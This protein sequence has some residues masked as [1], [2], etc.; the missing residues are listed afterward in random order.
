MRFNSK[1]L[2]KTAVKF[3]A[4]MIRCI[5]ETDKEWTK[6]WLP[7]KRKNYLPRN[8]SG[9]HYSGGNILMLLINAMYFDF[10]TP[11]FLTFNQA[12][13]IGILIKKGAVS[14]PVYHI[15]YMYYDPRTQ[16]KISIEKYEILDPAEQK[17][18]YLIPT[19]KCYDVFNLDQTNYS[20]VYPEEWSKILTCHAELTSE[21]TS[22]I[23]TNDLLDSLIENQDW[24]CPI[25][26]RLSN[27]A[28]YSVSGDRIVLP[29]KHQFPDQKSFYAT[30]LHEM[31]HSTGHPQRLN[32]IKR[33]AKDHQDNYAKEELVAE[34]SA[35]LMGYY[36]GIEVRIREDHTSYLKNWLEEL[37]KDNTYLMDILSDVIQVVKYICKHL[38]YNPFEQAEKINTVSSIK[39]SRKESIPELFAIDELILLD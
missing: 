10:R 21:K 8:I 26:E 29:Q 32:R 25:E 9:R 39:K 24:I 31:A 3:T 14:F 38:A 33:T 6:P 28:Y 18:Y 22:T 1:K 27:R 19:P 4:L 36:L 2:E 16:D 17:N 11:V 37:R 30:E 13:E 35:A 34:L 15:P 12:K 20:E 5:E 23:Y 7:V